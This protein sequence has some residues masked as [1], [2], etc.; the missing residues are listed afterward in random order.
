LFILSARVGIARRVATITAVPRKHPASSMRT[1]STA[2]GGGRKYGVSCVSWTGRLPVTDGSVHG[3][4]RL[5]HRD[6][7]DAFTDSV[8]LQTAAIRRLISIP[9][10]PPSPADPLDAMTIDLE[11]LEETERESARR[12]G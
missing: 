12:D 5:A 1:Y 2:P 7:E 10:A 6:G 9:T 8:E 11:P 3:R 4:A